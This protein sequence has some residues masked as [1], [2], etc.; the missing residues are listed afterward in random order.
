MKIKIV[1]IL[2]VL[3]LMIF[4][5]DM[6]AYFFESNFFSRYFP[7]LLGLNFIVFFAAQSKDY[8]FL[9]IALTIIFLSCMIRNQ[10]SSLN[11]ASILINMS[12]GIYLYLRNPSRIAIS[13]LMVFFLMMLIGRF[14]ISND[15]EQILTSGSVNYI[16][17]IALSGTALYYTFVPE[18]NRKVNILP[19]LVTCVLCILATG[20]SGV[21]CSIIL[22]VG[23]FLYNYKFVRTNLFMNFSYIAILLFSI[24]TIIEYADLLYAEDSP[25][26]LFYRFGSDYTQD[27]R[28]LILN[29]YFSNFGFFDFLFGKGNSS[30][31]EAVGLSVHIS[32]L[33]WHISLGVFAI[34]LYIFV[35]FAYFKMFLINKLYWLIM[36]VIILRAT[37]DHVMLTAAF[38]FGPLL[39]YF[40]AV[41]YHP[42][43]L[44]LKTKI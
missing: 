42:Y 35:L 16:S 34:P 27:G 6:G 24:L 37:T 30:I 12:I 9:S 38:I 44:S 18:R 7:F 17:V 13:I 2:D 31:R 20:R 11:I 21:V 8:I 19:A 28:A 22:L 26:T 32:Y 1:S 29:E 39:I 36:T 10:D 33:Q 25:S 40:C 5:V 15:I 43:Y 14:Y 41:V 4:A 23:L 3:V